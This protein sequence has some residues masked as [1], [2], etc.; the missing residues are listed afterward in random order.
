MEDI[1]SELAAQA[2]SQVAENHTISNDNAE[3]RPNTFEGSF[4]PV[5]DP[6]QLNIACDLLRGGDAI[7]TINNLVD[8]AN[9]VYH[10]IIELPG[11]RIQSFW[12]NRYWHDR[13][14]EAASTF[15][16]EPEEESNEEIE[17]TVHQEIPENSGSLLVDE[18]T[19]RFSGAIW[20][21]AIQKKVIVLAG[22]GGIGRFGNLIN[23]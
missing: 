18:T 21:E 19:S 22:V 6:E 9:F 13:L 15:E 16:E 4:E 1:V 10:V 14:T 12:V 11:D 8:S 20:Y 7:I 5:G 2:L 23:F 3:E 17:E